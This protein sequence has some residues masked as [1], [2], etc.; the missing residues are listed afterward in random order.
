M[1]KILLVIILLVLPFGCFAEDATTV[2]NDSIDVQKHKD[3]EGELSREKD[4]NFEWKPVAC[5]PGL[6]DAGE[7]PGWTKIKQDKKYKELVL[8]KED[9]QYCLES[10]RK[11]MIKDYGVDIRLIE[12]G[13]ITVKHER[14]SQDGPIL[15]LKPTIKPYRIEVFRYASIMAVDREG[16]IYFFQSWS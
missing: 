15:S 3:Y 12:K 11:E 4:Y 8:T 6:R 10:Y 9:A 7:Q 16:N 2:S 5:P 13:T 1:K 14:Q